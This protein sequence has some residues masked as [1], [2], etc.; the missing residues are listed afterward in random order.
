MGRR[1]LSVECGRV[2]KALLRR[3]AATQISR[4][5]AKSA[6]PLSFLARAL[7]EPWSVIVTGFA[8]TDAV[9][10]SS[11]L[12]AIDDISLYLATASSV[13]G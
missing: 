10:G 7:S 12:F 9:G 4:S 5:A 8:D 6:P 2:G 3:C 1:V 11:D 13:I